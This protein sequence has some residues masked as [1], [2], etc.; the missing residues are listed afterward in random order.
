MSDEKDTSTLEKLD[1]LTSFM[2]TNKINGHEV[3]EW[4]TTQFTHLYP[5][6]RTLTVSL[7]EGGASFENLR[8]YL[9]ENWPKLVDAVV[10]HMVPIILISCPTVTKEYLDKEPFTTGLSFIIAIFKQNMDHV[11]DFFGQ[12]GEV[13]AELKAQLDEATK[14]LSSLK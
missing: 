3:K 6:L 4:T 14:N 1:G 2:Q 10:P 9:G 11:A 5:Y 12:A 13:P 8:S 7:Q